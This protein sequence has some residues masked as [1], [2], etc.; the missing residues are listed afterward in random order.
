LRCIK[1]W[2]V[3]GETTL[4][5]ARSACCRAETPAPRAY[6]MFTQLGL[7]HLAV[8]DDSGA[9]RGIITRRDLDHAAG[10]G[11]WRRNRMAP[12]PEGPAAGAPRGFQGFLGFKPPPPAC[13]AACVRM[14]GDD[15]ARPCLQCSSS[16]H[17]RL[18]LC[19]GRWLLPGCDIPR[20]E[21]FYSRMITRCSDLAAS[22]R[23]QC[24][25]EA[26]I[27]AQSCRWLAIDR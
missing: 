12:P 22:G 8:T 27:P 1:A 4:T 13:S 23:L 9:V 19:P 17:D 18:H 11:A 16:A 25:R 21:R 6:A 15:P 26:C 10:H 14:M 24:M 7:R 3:Q 2:T 20:G 5:G